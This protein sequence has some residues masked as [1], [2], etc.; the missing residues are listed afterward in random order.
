NL[1][2]ILTKPK[3]PLVKQ[4]QKKLELHDLEKEFEEV[5]LIEIAK[6]EIERNPGARGLRSIFEGLML[7]VMYELPSRKEIE[8]CNIKKE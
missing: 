7:D 8:K 3:N 4:F 1:D 2:Q 6:K 5:E